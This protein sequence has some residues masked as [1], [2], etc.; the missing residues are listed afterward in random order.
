ME[1]EHIVLPGSYDI[2][3]NRNKCDRC[4][5]VKPTADGIN[6]GS[7]FVCGRCW[8]KRQVYRTSTKAKK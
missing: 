8:R 7:K 1:R 5:E 4:G 3:D 6:M 2:G